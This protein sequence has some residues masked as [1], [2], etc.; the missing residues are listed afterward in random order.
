MLVLRVLNLPLVP[1]ARLLRLLNLF[2]ELDL[3][4]DCPARATQCGVDNF[5]TVYRF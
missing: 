3:K 4:E 1:R 5:H 2:I